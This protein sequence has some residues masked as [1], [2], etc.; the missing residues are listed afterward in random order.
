[1]SEL[2]HKDISNIVYEQLQKLDIICAAVGQ[3][4]GL[5]LL[6]FSFSDNEEGCKSFQSISS[7]HGVNCIFV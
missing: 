7:P 1:V 6:L 2:L 5:N 4:V 3:T